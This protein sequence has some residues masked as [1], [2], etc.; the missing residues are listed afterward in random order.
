MIFIFLAEFPCETNINKNVFARN[1][2]SRAYFRK[3]SD[4]SGKFTEDSENAVKKKRRMPKGKVGRLRP[5]RNKNALVLI[6]FSL[7]A[8][9]IR[10][11]MPK[12]K[13]GRL[14]PFRPK[15]LRGSI[16]PKGFSFSGL[17]FPAPPVSLK[18]HA[19][20]LTILLIPRSASMLTP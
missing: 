1:V 13:A 9:G 18:N 6:K 8:R 5:L 7:L 4:D 14:R 10:R 15:G 2:P 17:K 19:L 16:T 3:Y 20:K 11:R 12:G